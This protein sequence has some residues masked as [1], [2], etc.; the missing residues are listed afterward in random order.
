M[1]V[2]GLITTVNAAFQRVAMHAVREALLEAQADVA[3]LPLVQIPIPWPCTNEQ[4]E[5]AMRRF[6]G[7]ICPAWGVTHIAFGDLFL[8]DVRTYRESRLAGTGITPLFPLWGEP[9]DKLAR[10]MV[11]GGL[12]A[13]LTCIDPKQLPATFAGRIFDSSL[14]DEL[15]HEVDPCGERGE[16]HT[17][18]TKGPMLT[19]PLSVTV[20]EIVWR[21]NFVF[22]D[23]LLAE[24]RQEREM[25]RGS[26]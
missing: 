16:F 14:L 19:R 9:T 10:E 26:L 8:E 17:F 5:E 2:V 23:V 20:G 11:A 15:P 13:I 1:E 6:I 4:Y 22:A 3:G 7:Q 21:D 24:N 12:E 25:R 18:V